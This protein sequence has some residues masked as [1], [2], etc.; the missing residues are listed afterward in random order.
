MKGLFFGAPAG[1]GNSSL[2]EAAT[3]A[4]CPPPLAVSPIEDEL[5][6]P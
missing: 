5:E 3:L 4:V 6:A 1:G 2:P